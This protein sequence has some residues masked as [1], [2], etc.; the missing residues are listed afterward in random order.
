MVEKEHLAA[1]VPNFRLDGKV[2]LVT[3][4][5]SGLGA[6]FSQ[7]L[8]GNGA[9]VVLAARRLD[10]L[11]AVA[12]KIQ[13]AGGVATAVQMD[14]TDEASVEAAWDA[15]TQSAGLPDIVVNNSGVPGAGAFAHELPTE[16]WDAVF[17]TNARGVW[18]TSRTGAR[19]LI[20]AGRPGAIINIASIRAH[21]NTKLFAPYGA[22]K[23]AVVSL[24]Q[25]MALELSRFGIRVNALAPGY[26]AT[27]LNDGLF[28]TDFGRDMIQRIPQRRLGDMH[29]LDGALLLLASDA[30]SYMSG[31]TI[32]VDGGHSH[33][34]V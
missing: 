22:S 23:A 5:S 1:S 34:S 31:S 25:N 18:L 21:L 33:A 28:E 10:A 30:G 19:R 4:A 15:A 13:A 17:D 2:A 11:A 3:G 9:K 8:A 32:V 20:A 24:T 12:A 29:E 6:H 16:V 26:F 14:V 27:P 7:T